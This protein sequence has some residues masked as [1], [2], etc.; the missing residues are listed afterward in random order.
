MIR[1]NTI[2]LETQ[3]SNFKRFVNNVLST[4]R[5]IKSGF[6]TIYNV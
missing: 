4:T 1:A 5:E 6:V 2:Q 3:V